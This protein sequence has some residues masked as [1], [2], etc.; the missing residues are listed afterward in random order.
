[1]GVLWPA[2]ERR[3]SKDET[4]ALVT[5]RNARVSDSYDLARFVEAQ[6][7]R[8][9]YGRAL[10]ELRAGAK[11]SHWM[12]F[13]F[14]QLA[15]LGASPMAQRYAIA[16]RDEAA[17]YLAHPVLGPRLRDCVA[18]VNAVDGRTAHEIFGSPD[19]LKFHSCLTLFA[20]AT[21][22]NAGFLTALAKYYGGAFDP[23]SMR[24][25]GV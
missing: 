1:M 8:G 21:A 24:R 10:A 23:A 4:A 15:G 2:N 13:V 22:D 3:R 11:Q 6:D 25:L 5:C 16:S 17:A 12:W 20:H 14:P 7:A 19:D 18:A 9:T